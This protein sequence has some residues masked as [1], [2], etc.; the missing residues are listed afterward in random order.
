MDEI[1]D[2]LDETGLRELIMLLDETPGQ[3]IVIS[4]N[5]AFKDYFD[6]KIVVEK[7]GGVSAINDSE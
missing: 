1:A 4:H 6:N 5:D 2:A 3:K 7:T